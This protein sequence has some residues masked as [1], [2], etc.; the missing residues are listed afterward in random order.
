MAAHNG[1]DLCA[2]TRCLPLVAAVAVT[3]A[4]ISADHRDWSPSHPAAG[5]VRRPF[6]IGLTAATLFAAGAVSRAALRVRSPDAFTVLVALRSQPFLTPN[7][8]RI[9]IRRQSG[10]GPLQL[11]QS[12]ATWRQVPGELSP[13]GP[14]RARRG[15]RTPSAFPVLTS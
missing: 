8:R 6:P 2:A 1:P 14:S 13:C 7:R 12:S 11:P 10:G 4:V 9:T 15:L 5:F 3:V